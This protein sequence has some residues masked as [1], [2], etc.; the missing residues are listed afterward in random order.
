MIIIFHH[1]YVSY[2]Q[3]EFVDYIWQHSVYAFTTLLIENL[4]N[5]SLIPSKNAD[6][7]TLACNVLLYNLLTAQ[8]IKPQLSSILFSCMYKITVF[9]IFLR[10]HIY[11]FLGNL[12][13]G[14]RSW[15]WMHSTQ[16]NTKNQC[17]RK[18]FNRHVHLFATS[19]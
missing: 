10:I 15:N 16:W 1:L 3:S 18:Y 6:K 14:I 9:S 17:N 7:K 8:I 11:K 2:H 19:R 5:K 12:N 13:L 4:V